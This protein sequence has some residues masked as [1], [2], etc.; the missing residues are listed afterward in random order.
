MFTL[1]SE[2]IVPPRADIESAG[3]F[4]TFEGRVRAKN[5]G[6]AV[7]FLEY[8]AYEDLALSAGTAL[9]EEAKK[10]FGLDWAFAV[11]RVGKLDLGEV[12]IWIGCAAAHRKEA[13][14]ACEFLIDEMKRRVPIWKK[15][16]YVDGDSEW[17]NL[18]QQATPDVLVRSDVFA[19]QIVMP[20]VGPAGQIAL[21]QARVLMVGAGGLAS[22]ALPYLAGAGIGSI[23]IVEP[24]LL[25]ASNLHRQVLFGS[26]DLGRSKARLAAESMR[27]LHPFVETEVIEEYLDAS[28]AEQIVSSYDVVIDGTDRFDAKFLM[29]DVCVQLGK[30]LVQASIYRFDG[31]VQTILPG[32]PCLRCQWPEAPTDGCVS[33][34]SEAG[35]LGVVPGLFGVLQATEV[36]K[37]LLGFGNPLS[38][39]QLF[40]DLEGP[41][42]QKIRRTRRP[43]C[44]AGGRCRC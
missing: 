39:D 5:E 15:E 25:E 18:G 42:F 4:V 8:E 3:G 44:Q 31:Y 34:C 1:T 28:N 30:P 22:S 40:L 41:T 20:E 10:K 35:V 21:Q 33:T 2:T 11:H 36:L 14:L 12:A 32:G 19:R 9:V 38:R 24:G 43:G 6:R 7:E 27:R 13:F 26:D 29:N 16:H 37:I 23:G 17:V